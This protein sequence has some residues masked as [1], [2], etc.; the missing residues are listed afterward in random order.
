MTA[1]NHIVGGVAITGI[2]CSFWDVNIFADVSYLTV[3]IFTSLLPDIDHPK[4][5]MGRVFFPIAKWLDKNYGHRTITH[6]LTLFLPLL[7]LCRLAGGLFMGEESSSYLL[8]F[9][10][11]YLSHLI[12]DMLTVHGVPLFYPFLRNPCVMPANPNF[13]LEAAM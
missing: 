5:I 13:R 6:S 7:L 3:V 10:F 1:A 4:S 9:G 2:S 12:L 11:A 8:I